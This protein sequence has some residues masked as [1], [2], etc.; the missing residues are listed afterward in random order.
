MKSVHQ[1]CPQAPA[2]KLVQLRPLSEEQAFQRVTE[3]M[4]SSFAASWWNA[5]DGKRLQSVGGRS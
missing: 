1:T 2:P 4:K 5:R 3:R